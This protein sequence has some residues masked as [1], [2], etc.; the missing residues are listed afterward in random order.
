MPDLYT[1]TNKNKFTGGTLSDFEMFSIIYHNIFSYPLSFSDL[2]RWR[3][4][5]KCQILNTKGRVFSKNDIYFLEGQAGLIYKRILR[6]RVSKKKF[7]TAKKAAKILSLIPNIKMVAVTGSLAMN[8][9]ADESDIDFLVITKAGTLWTTRLL[10]YFV[11]SVFGIKT[12]KPND[13]NQKDKLCF[14]VW[15]D[16][17]DLDWRERNIYTS[18]EIAQIVPLVNKDKTYERFLFRNKWILN[19][20]PNAVKI[21]RYR[22]ITHSMS[23]HFISSVVEKICYWI[24]LKYMK[25]KITREIVTK[26]RALFH[27]QDWGKVVLD[28]VKSISVE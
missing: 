10:S 16:E 3:A 17:D 22:D 25:P 4:G 5:G 6:R 21:Q 7:E 1:V 11:V 9:S 15:L 2:I 12:R 28:R 18:H 20:W 27:P 8:N 13:K 23:I 19:Y 26:T 14:N 24:Q